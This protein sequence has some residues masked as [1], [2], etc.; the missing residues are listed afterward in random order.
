MWE[1]RLMQ[2]EAGQVVSKGR[3]APEDG[4]RYVSLSII[5]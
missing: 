4:A 3:V 5:S 1:Y 2:T